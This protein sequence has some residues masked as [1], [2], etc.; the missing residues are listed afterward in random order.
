MTV[1]NGAKDLERVIRDAAKQGDFHWLI[2]DNGSTDE[3]Q[4]IIEELSKELKIKKMW[5]PQIPG[6]TGRQNN[7]VT[8]HEMVKEVK[9]PYLFWLDDDILLGQASIKDLKPFLNDSVG[10]VGYPYGPGPH[11]RAGAMMMKT[12]VAKRIN[13]CVSPHCVCASVQMELSRI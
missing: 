1:Y 4:K 9:T 7:A 3:T 11:L 12:D 6:L 8:R 13:H 5:M 2:C 10:A